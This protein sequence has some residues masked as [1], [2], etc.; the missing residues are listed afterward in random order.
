MV[1]K[2][3]QLPIQLHCLKYVHL[4]TYF[5]KLMLNVIRCLNY[6]STK[7]YLIKQQPMLPIGTGNIGESFEHKQTKDKFI[8]EFKWATPGLFFVYFQFFQLNITI[9]TT[10]PCEQ[11]PY[12]IWHRDLNSQPSDYQP[13]PLTTR[14]GLLP[15]FTFVS[16]SFHTFGAGSVTTMGDF[17]LFGW[18]LKL[19]DNYFGGKKQPKIKQDLGTF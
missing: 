14:P 12:S 13:P 2:F 10:N 5:I 9:F 4:C 11:C 8:F 16:F 6:F 1:H 19:G 3:C 7:Q 18:L 17:R 15:N